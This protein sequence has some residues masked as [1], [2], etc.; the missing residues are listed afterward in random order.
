ML[1]RSP[2]LKKTRSHVFCGLQGNCHSRPALHGF[3]AEPQLFTDINS[4]SSTTEENQANV[5]FSDGAAA[6]PDAL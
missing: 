6:R 4:Q 3:V 5:T 1:K 2:R